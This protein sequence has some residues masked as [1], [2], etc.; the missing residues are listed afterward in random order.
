[1]NDEDEVKGI[2]HPTKRFCEHSHPLKKITT[3]K[4]IE[5]RWRSSG[6]VL[7]RLI[8]LSNEHSRYAERCFCKPVIM[9]KGKEKKQKNLLAFAKKKGNTLALF[10]RVGRFLAP[11]PSNIVV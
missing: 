9:R 10:N 2:Y 3:K 4:S 6:K 11:S 8:T 5:K 1:M 7:H